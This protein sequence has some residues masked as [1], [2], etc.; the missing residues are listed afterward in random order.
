MFHLMHSYGWSGQSVLIDLPGEHWNSEDL[1]GSSDATQM[2]CA[3]A[4]QWLGSGSSEIR[5]SDCDFAEFRTELFDPTSLVD[6]WSDDS[7]VEPFGCPDIPVID[8]TQMERDAK[9]YLPAGLGSSNVI[10]TS[11]PGNRL[12]CCP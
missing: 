9:S 11:D 4:F 10:T 5:G 6:G 7:E 12:P 8:F 3:K 2:V 1:L